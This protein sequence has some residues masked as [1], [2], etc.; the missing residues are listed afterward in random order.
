M[1]RASSRR[2]ASR[3]RRVCAC[4]GRAGG[5]GC[6]D[7]A[8]AETG[9]GGGGES[10]C[11]VNN[12]HTPSRTHRVE[13][14][15]GDDVEE[16][17]RRGHA[18]DRGLVRIQPLLHTITHIPTILLVLL[19]LLLLLLQGLLPL[20]AIAAAAATAAAAISGGEG[21]QPRH[22]GIEAPVLPESAVRLVMGMVRG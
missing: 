6:V 22:Q 5:T 17:R 4:F 9:P 13:A 20:A 19:L 18:P 11:R 14:K 8:L 1:T 7:V 2:M 10:K 3:S 21:L 12:E 16:V 15:G